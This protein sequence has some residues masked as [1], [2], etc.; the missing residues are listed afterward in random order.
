MKIL[1]FTN[2]TSLKNLSSSLV[3]YEDD[4][5]NLIPNTFGQLLRNNN[6]V[7]REKTDWK[8]SNNVDEVKSDFILIKDSI[9][10]KVYDLLINTFSEETYF[11]IY[12][13]QPESNDFEI[14]KRK[15]NWIGE[16]N[17]TKANHE[18]GNSTYQPIANSIKSADTKSDKEIV[19]DIDKEL[20]LCSTYFK[21][22]AESFIQS[23]EY[24]YSPNNFEYKTIIS[25]N[26]LSELISFFNDN[27]YNSLD[28]ILH[29][30]FENL[31]KLIFNNENVVFICHK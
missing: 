25:N 27:K 17:S 31:K 5:C 14:Y 19:I 6:F 16:T 29:L 20:E 12:H 18:P 28:N 2:Y 9:E 11:V 13:R 30:K 4:E 26:E 23:I 21:K 24:G 15:Y 7:F 3:T 22:C 1:V 8:G 10:K